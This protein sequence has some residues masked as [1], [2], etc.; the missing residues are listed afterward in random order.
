MQVPSLLAKV[1]H[2]RQAPVKVLSASGI[3]CEIKRKNNNTTILELSRNAPLEKYLIRIHSIK[4]YLELNRL[5][6]NS[7][8]YKVGIGLMYV[9]YL[10]ISLSLS[11]TI[12]GSVSSGTS[13]EVEGGADILFATY[14]HQSISFQPQS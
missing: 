11:V 4:M 2:V 14:L 7:K 12:T 13:D 10:G 8:H 3:K 6:T 9:R 1:L 5:G